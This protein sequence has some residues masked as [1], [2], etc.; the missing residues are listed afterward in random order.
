MTINQLSILKV[1]LEKITEWQCD[2][3]F[4]NISNAGLLDKYNNLTKVSQ[5]PFNTNEI[6]NKIKADYYDNYYCLLKKKSIIHFLE[7]GEHLF[8]IYRLFKY[9]EINF[10]L[11]FLEKSLNE[12]DE[13]GNWVHSQETIE[14]DCWTVTHEVYRQLHLIRS[15]I[16]HLIENKNKQNEK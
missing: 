9:T 4:T 15:S 10:P 7:N 1:Y 2:V 16:K 6:I 11:D 12:I 14:T 5:E 3:Q 8:N 13:F